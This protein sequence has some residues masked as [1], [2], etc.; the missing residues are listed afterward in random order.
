M[1]S[2]GSTCSSGLVFKNKESSSRNGASIFQYNGLKPVQTMQLRLGSAAS[3]P[4]APRSRR[5]RAMA[6]PNVSAP[7]R[8]TDPKK[9]I[10]ITGMGLVSVFGSEVDKFYD[11]LLE[12]Q[13]GISLIDRFDSSSYSV[14]F[15]GQIRDFSTEGYIDG[16]NDRRLD[17]CWRYCLVAGKRALSDA[18]LSQ[19]V[20]DTMDKS[21]I[22]VLVGS[23]MGG[24]TVFSNGVEA[25]V[26]KG[27]KKITPFFIPYSITNMGSALLAIDTGLMGPNYSISTA[28]ATANYC[29]Y[30]AA[31]HI[32]R[33]EANIMVVG[34]TEAAVIPAGVGG[35]IAC[36]AL[37]QRNDEPEKA[38]R[39]W[40]KN[41]D[42]FVIGEGSGVLVMESLEHAMK[43][44]ANIIAEYLGGAVTCDAHHMTDPR[45]DGLGVSSCITK[46]LDDAGV[47]VEEV[48]YI[49]AHA[50]S[51]LAGDLAEVN[52]VKKVFK[53]TS[54]IKMNGTKSMIGHGLGAAGGLEAIA[55]IK[56]ITTGW[57]HPTINQ[58]DLEP[59][60]TIDT[61]PNVK[62]QHEVNVAISN[63]F[64]FGGHNSVVVFAPFNP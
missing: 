36:R 32:R 4:K 11:C 53:D 33:G 55:T 3:K 21:K 42:G 60:V 58:Y 16:K 28:C 29:F 30:A 19:Q 15:G 61:V 64:G 56:A 50:T 23:G 57:L 35:F 8:E 47:S 22:G 51:T 27:Y 1:S 18:N 48:N 2:I 41:R 49:N 5:I 44:G 63:S 24:L 52:A 20:L 13:S 7:K 40:D 34:G 25:L 38:S 46:S 31:N 9:R 37:S 10:V 12:G 26:K 17:D 62:K 39:P 6:S 54:E 43:R 59:E 45:S 14:R